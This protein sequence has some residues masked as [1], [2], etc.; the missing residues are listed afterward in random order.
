MYVKKWVAFASMMVAASL[1][2]YGNSSTPVSQDLLITRADS[3]MIGD[4]LPMKREASVVFRNTLQDVGGKGSG[5]LAPWDTSRST[6]IPREQERT[7]TLPET[8]TGLLFMI[9]LLTLGSLGGMRSFAH[10]ASC[11]RAISSVCAVRNTC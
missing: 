3:T 11:R 2:A 6:E 4:R 1:P 7:A 10:K 5:L 9:G 8:N